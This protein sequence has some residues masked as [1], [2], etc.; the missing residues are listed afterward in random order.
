M[1]GRRAQL[2]VEVVDRYIRTRQPVSSRQLATAYRHRFSS[3]TIRSELLALEGEGYLYKPY[4][5]AGRVPTARGFRFFAEW[6]LDVAELGEGNPSVPAERQEVEPGL[7]P[8][9][10]RRTATVL[11]A[12]TRALG[13]VVPPPRHEARLNTLI[14]RR[15]GPSTVLVVTL[16][17]LGAVESRF[18]SL[19][20]DLEPDELSEAEA[21]L[22]RWLREHTLA[23]SPLPDQPFPDGWHSR[24][25]LGALA[26]LRGL[27]EGEPERRVYVE[28]WPHLLAELAVRS[29]EWALAR[30]QAL[31]R[32]LE[33][34]Q[35]FAA[36][37]HRL[38]EGREAGIAV[39]VGDGSVP[40]LED[41]SLVAAPYL[42]GSGVVGVV[43]PLWM[44]Y[45]RAFSAARYVAGRLG[46]ILAAGSGKEE[47]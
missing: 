11:A 19:D 22:C 16:S 44:D 45:A 26:I 24:A 35:A 13:L 42:A 34:E 15:V 17:E 46:A 14:A 6:L 37:V 3:A 33:E 47:G 10:F 29:P 27:A 32:L 18:V 36:L 12:M 40:E 4:P 25:A 43:G 28:G 2:L 38:R 20:L 30:G 39:H 8:D 1:H 9:L 31:L 41:L 5:S 21:F 7:L 23:D